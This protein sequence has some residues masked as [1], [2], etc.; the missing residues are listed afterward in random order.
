MANKKIST[1]ELDFDTIKSN[2]KTYL[3]GQTEF[4]DYDFEGSGLSILLDVLAY[5]THY[6][7]LYTNLAVN[8]S[9]LD[10]ASKRS[11]VVSLSKQLGY[12]PYSVTAAKAV[13]DIVVS[14]PTIF[15]TVLTIP[16]HAPLTTIIDGVSY[17]FYTTSSITTPYADGLY[18]F[19][20]VELIEGSPLTFRYEVGNDPATQQFTIP[21]TNAD[22]STLIVKVQDSATSSVYNVYNFE[23]NILYSTNQTKTYTINEFD[24]GLY[25]ITFGDGVMSGLALIPGN[26]VHLEYM[27]TAGPYANG[28]RLFSYQDS[29]G[30]GGVTSVTTTTAALGGSNIES[31]ESIRYNAP[32]AFS[33]QNRA[34]TVDDYRTLILSNF[35]EADVVSCWGGEDNYPPTYGKVYVCVK[36]KTASRLTSTQKSYIT[37]SILGDKTVSSLGIEIVDPE[38]INI[39]LEVSIYYNQDNTSL[40]QNSL[41]SIAS[42][43]IVN[44]NS[45]ELVSF[46]S[47]FR[48]SKL[49]RLIDASDKSF[50]NSSMTVLLSKDV[51]VKYNINSQYVLNLINPIYRAEMPA[52]AVKSNKFYVSGSSDVYYIDDDGVGNLRLNRIDTELNVSVANPA[53]GTVDYDLGKII[54]DKLNIT[55]LVDLDFT[56]NIKPRSNDVV[57]ALHQLINIDSTKLTINLIADR[58]ASGDSG[59]GFNYVFTPSR[60]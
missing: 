37:N 6:N 53:L 5:N 59:S 11:S 19:T 45:S 22:I 4:Q 17:T 27:T 33:A 55:N 30:V 21:N 44:Y 3:Q 1:T 58:T 60:V 25:R 43:T 9:F 48:Y 51:V 40:S 39:I 35:P 54:V 24:D 14:S 15:P 47:V 41:G 16:K 20:D 34:V 29:L 10:S 50:A 52:E 36:P 42:N 49:T 2:L 13:V 56:F 31:I 57:S 12:T 28:A 18:T 46:D 23:S 38:Y 26:I 8:E 7:A 32:K